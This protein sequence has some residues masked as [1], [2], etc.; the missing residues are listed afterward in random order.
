MRLTEAIGNAFATDHE[1]LERKLEDHRDFTAIMA[2]VISVIGALLWIWDLVHDAANAPRTLG[3][4]LSMPVFGA[5]LA[6]ALHWRLPRPW[7]TW[8]AFLIHFVWLATFVAIIDRLDTGMIY[9][10]AGF[11]YFF[12]VG[13]LLLQ[14]FSLRVNL[15]YT[16]L[17][18]VAPHLMAEAGLADGFQHAFYAVL[19]YPA[20]LM[21]MAAQVTIAASYAQRRQFE[22][23]LEALAREDALTGLANRRHFLAQLTH[24]LLRAR[25][26]R[27]P[28]SLALLDIDHFKQVNDRHGHPA[29]DRAIAAVG[30]A[31][32]EGLRRTDL[33]GRLGGEEF[34]LLLP[35][36][37][38][39]DATQVADKLRAAL[40][41][42]PIALE[43]GATLRITVS[44]GVAEARTPD[45]S[46][47]QLIQRA[48]AALY[49][50]KR[51][52]RNR[53]VAAA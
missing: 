34:G 28:L 43:G 13:L 36:T 37:A 3:L 21:T 29:G 19:I 8:L 44:L 14:P 22:R 33:A 17:A 48:D 46:P 20:M 53:V 26:F 40:A 31:C 6:T 45:E 38:L 47:E 11:M 23:L 49:E 25:R 7:L 51:G 12:L 39:A 35:G 52:G 9:G 27:Y 18:A 5:V 2:L 4:R 41:S 50:A 32:G 10:L 30:R 1:F 24:E 15:A 16:A 42:A